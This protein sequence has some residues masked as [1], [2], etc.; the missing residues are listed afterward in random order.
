MGL[1]ALLASPRLGRPA[2]ELCQNLFR[3][4]PLDPAD[5]NRIGAA[6]QGARLAEKERFDI[7]RKR[8]ATRHGARVNLQKIYPFGSGWQIG[9]FFPPSEKTDPHEAVAEKKFLRKEAASDIPRL[10]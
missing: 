2:G 3:G 8:R 1:D 4:L 5:P 7:G 10:Q 9:D 6:A